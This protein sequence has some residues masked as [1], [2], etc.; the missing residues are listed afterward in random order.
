MKNATRFGPSFT[1]EELWD[2]SV[3]DA[4]QDLQVAGLRQ[5][6]SLSLSLC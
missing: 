2:L 3:T 4:L 1:V 6:L 5:A